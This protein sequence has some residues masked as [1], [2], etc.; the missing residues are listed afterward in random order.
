MFRPSRGHL[1]TDIW[2]VSVSIQIMCGRISLPHVMC[3]KVKVKQSHYRPGQAL[4][5]PGGWISQ[6]SKQSAPEGGKVVSPMHPQEIFLVVISV[7]GWIIPRAIVRPEKLCQWKIPMTQSEIE[8]AT[9]RLVAQ[10]L[11]QLRHRV[12]HYPTCCTVWGLNA[13]RGNIF[14]TFPKCSYR[15]WAP[16]IFI[17]KAH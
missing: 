1:L 14:F 6:I 13:G 17:L 8:L 10:C 4:R 12:P 7:R 15:L 9:F 2:N 3:I 16:S 11:N 5:V